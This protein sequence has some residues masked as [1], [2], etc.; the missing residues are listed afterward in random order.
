MGATVNEDFRPSSLVVQRIRPGGAGESVAGTMSSI[1]HVIAS[2]R[3]G[4]PVDEP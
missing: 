4:A 3:A 1:L 2:A